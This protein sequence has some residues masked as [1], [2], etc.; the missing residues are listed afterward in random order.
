MHEFLRVMCC[1]MLVAA[2]AGCGTPAFVDNLSTQPRSSSFDMNIFG[3]GNYF[4]YEHAF[5]DAAAETVRKN[6]ER[7]CGQKKLVPVK[8]SGTCSLSRC[9]THFQCMKPDE[10]AAYQK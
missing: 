10:A 8:T 1:L 4:T 2:T 5:T 6:A 9:T 7:Q 3:E